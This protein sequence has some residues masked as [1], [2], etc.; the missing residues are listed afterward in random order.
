M[1]NPQIDPALQIDG[2]DLNGKVVV[3]KEECCSEKYSAIKFRLRKVFGGF[4]ANP[5]GMGRA[6]LAHFLYCGDGGRWDRSDI[7][8]LATQEEI[9]QVL[10]RTNIVDTPFGPLVGP[11]ETGVII[12]LK[13]DRRHAECS[14]LQDP[15]S[16]IY[17]Q[18]LA[19]I[20]GRPWI[21][22]DQYRA[23]A[24]RHIINDTNVFVDPDAEVER[25]TDGG[26]YVTAKILI[27]DGEIA[28]EETP[29]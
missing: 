26:A 7:E 29:A 15:C 12:K 18:W 27:E 23:A 5:K 14:E 20:Q 9:D 11:D 13:E 22:E 17:E 28:P 10:T 6:I 1:M 24:R 19:A 16:D 4:G 21:T 3:V 25:G 8:R 2:I